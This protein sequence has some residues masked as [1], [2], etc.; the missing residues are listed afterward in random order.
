V[1]LRVAK[2]EAEASFLLSLLILHLFFLAPRGGK[3]RRSHKPEQHK[4][5]FRLQ[6]LKK[7]FNIYESKTLRK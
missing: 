6:N 5:F 1:R 3:T 7:P 4:G 2:N